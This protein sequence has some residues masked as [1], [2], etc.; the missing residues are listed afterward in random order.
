MQTLYI[1]FSFLTSVGILI[2]VYAFYRD[3][4]KLTLLQKIALILVS[5]SGLMPMLL[6]MIEGFLSN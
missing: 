6:G 2:M 3:F 4:K 5:I 1:L